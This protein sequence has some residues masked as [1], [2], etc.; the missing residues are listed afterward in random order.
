MLTRKLSFM[1]INMH[2]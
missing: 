1:H 2:V